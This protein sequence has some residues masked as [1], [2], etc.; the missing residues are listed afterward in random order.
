MLERLDILDLD[1]V[2]W[3][4]ALSPDT[5]A[6]IEA[7]PA[8]ESLEIT[9]NGGHIWSMDG[10]FEGAFSFASPLSQAY[11]VEQLA[12]KFDAALDGDPSTEVPAFE[13]AA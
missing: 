3:F 12:P 7:M 10:V 6:Q 5:R 13:D 8:Y 2:I 9:V 11:V 1:T 4:A